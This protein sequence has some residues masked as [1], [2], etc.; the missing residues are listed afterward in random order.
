MFGHESA[1]EAQVI[2]LF[3]LPVAKFSKFFFLPFKVPWKRIQT[4]T[5]VRI[6]MSK[7]KWIKRSNHGTIEVNS[8]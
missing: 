4:I 5:D 3:A 1:I 7:S 6:H 2:K 8:H